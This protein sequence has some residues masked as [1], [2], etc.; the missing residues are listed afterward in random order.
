METINAKPDDIPSKLRPLM[1]A[2]TASPFHVAPERAAEMAQL[3]DKYGIR[4]QLKADAKD[5]LFEEFRI[6][7]LNRIFIG[8]RSLERLWAYCYAYTAITTEL[9]KAGGEF[10]NIE[11]QAEYQLAFNLLDW[12]SQERLE[13]REGEWPNTLQTHRNQMTWST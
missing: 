8:L 2:F 5:W 13:D 1:A 12:A 9:Q 7:E 11:N 4:I 10:S 3:R 6:F